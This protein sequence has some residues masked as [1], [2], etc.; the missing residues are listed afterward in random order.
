MEPRATAATIADGISAA[1]ASEDFALEL[2]ATI[3][4][5]ADS[6]TPKARK[7]GDRFRMSG[8]HLFADDGSANPNAATYVPRRRTCDAE[9]DNYGRAGTLTL[10][11][12]DRTRTR[13]EE[14]ERKKHPC[15]RATAKA[16]GG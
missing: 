4:D 13:E 15:T 10:L 11:D 16:T 6:N 7:K 9:T 14:D 12:R 5:A 8:I 2:Q 1:A 3:A